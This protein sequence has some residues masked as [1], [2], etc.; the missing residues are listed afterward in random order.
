MSSVG[1]RKSPSVD[2]RPPAWRRETSVE[3]SDLTHLQPIRRVN[4]AINEMLFIMFAG[5]LVFAIVFASLLANPAPRRVSRFPVL[6]VH[7]QD[8]RER[9]STRAATH[10]PRVARADEWRA[11]CRPGARHHHLGLSAPSILRTHDRQT[12]SFAGPAISMEGDPFSPC[13]HAW[14]HPL[15]THGIRSL[16][17]RQIP[18]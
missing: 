13:C 17:P 18:P 12:R 7:S 10:I 14:A 8:T 2:C 11:E 4:P 6:P 5:M 15:Q 1:R 3:V 9:L 16:R